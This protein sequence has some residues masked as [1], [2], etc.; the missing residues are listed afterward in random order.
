MVFW[1]SANIPPPPLL[2]LLSAAGGL[3]SELVLDLEC[4]FEAGLL[5]SNTAVAVGSG[6]RESVVKAL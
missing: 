5:D 2:P 1:S 3:E 6:T 4:G